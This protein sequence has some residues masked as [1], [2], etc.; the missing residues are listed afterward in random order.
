MVPEGTAFS[1]ADLAADDDGVRI[2]A[3]TDSYE[4]VD[5]LTRALADLPGL[6]SPEVRDVKTG[7]DGKV[8]FRIALPA[9]AAQGMP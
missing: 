1:V 4:A 5:V 7:V 2:R 3:R 9:A 8:E 6:G